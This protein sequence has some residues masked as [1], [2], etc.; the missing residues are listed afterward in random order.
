MD[1][2]YRLPLALVARLAPSPMRM[3]SFYLAKAD[4]PR[5]LQYLDHLVRIS[6]EVGCLMRLDE[7]LRRGSISGVD[8]VDSIP[9]SILRKLNSYKDVHLNDAARAFNRLGCLRLGGALRGLLLIKLVQQRF[10]SPAKQGWELDALLLEVSANDYSRRLFSRPELWEDGLDRQVQDRIELLRCS[11]MLVKLRVFVDSERLPCGEHEASLSGLSVLLQ[12][13]SRRESNLAGTPC[14]VVG[15]IGYS[16]AGS[17]ARLVEGRH[18]SFYRPYKIRAMIAE[19]LTERFN[20]VDL[21]VV[22]KR[23]LGVL[24]AQFTPECRVACSKVRE[25]FGL[26]FLNGGTEFLIW[27]LACDL[28]RLFVT[29]VDLFLNPAYPVGYLPSN[30]QKSHLSK[31]AAQWQTQ[32]WATLMVFGDHEPSQQYSIY[33]AFHGYDSVVYDS[34]LDAIVSAPF[35]AYAEALEDA[36]RVWPQGPV[37]D[38]CGGGSA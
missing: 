22:T 6:P 38:C 29:N 16:G 9:S 8:L 15:T 4:S 32:S 30:Y 28:N 21:A 12:G 11:D 3:I 25:R 27:L 14:D 2:A 26:G 1:L 13:P 19:G 5:A 18:V 37:V 20:D 31:D 23:G 34:M 36:Y 17:L 24:E 7:R 10:R 35:S 33:K